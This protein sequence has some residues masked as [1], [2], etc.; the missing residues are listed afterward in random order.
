[1]ER[2]FSPE[3]QRLARAVR[4][5]IQRDLDEGRFDVPLSRDGRAAAPSHAQRLV[6]QSLR[7]ERGRPAA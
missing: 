5:R 3:T 2:R 7:R 6:Q 1:M 4:D